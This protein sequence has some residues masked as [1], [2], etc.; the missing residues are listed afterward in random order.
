[1]LSKNFTALEFANTKDG[2]AIKLPDF[3]LVEKLQKLRDI[4]GSVTITSGYRTPR[5]NR[6]VKGSWNSNHLKGTAADIKFNFRPYNLNETI[7]L[8]ADLGFNNIGIYIKRGKFQWIHVD[9]SPR[10]NEVNGWRHVK[11]SSVKT[12]QI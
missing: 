10:W 2:Y 9:M 5:F 7:K 1:M 11:N 12:Y 8:L 3:E 6:R 4:V